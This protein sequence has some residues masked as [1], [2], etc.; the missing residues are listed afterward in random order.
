MH[1]L[2][3]RLR[4]KLRS[5]FRRR[6]LE[7][8]MAEEMRHHVELLE[9]ANRRAGL[10]P[11]EA[12]FAAR[13]QFGN[14]A[15]IQERAR[16][17]RGWRWL[18]QTGS[19]LRHGVRTALKNPGF[20]LVVIGTL[21]IGI[22]VNLAVFALLDAMFLRPLPG[23][24]H[25]SELV[26][27]G[28]AAGNARFGNT[29]YSVFRDYRAG[30]APVFSELA[31]FAEAEFGLA[32]ENRTDRVLGELVS[33]NYFTT[34]GVRMAAGRAFLPEEDEGA[35]RNPV[36]V[37]SFRLWQERWQGD[38]AVIGRTVSLNGHAC[39][40]VGVAERGFRALQLPNAHDIWVPLQMRETLF[41]AEPRALS[42]PGN[43]WL[44]RLVGKLA[45]GVTVEQAQEHLN[46][47]ARALQPAPAPG[48][49]LAWSHRLVEY[50]PFP[51]VNRTG[52]YAFFSILLAITLLVLG[53][54]TLNAANLFL[55]RA[56]A[57]R[58]ETA[59]RLALGASRG[60]LVRQM[61]AEGL[62]VATVAAGLGILGA[63]TAAAWLVGQIPGDFGDPLTV[64][65]VF[66]G[67]M[68]GAAAGLA[69]LT[70]LA[71]GLIPAWQGLQVNVLPALQTGEGAQTS[72]R[73]RLRSA[74]VVAQV[75]V[76]VVLVICAGLLARSLVRAEAAD[77]AG[78]TAGLLMA[79]VEP[80][81]N[82]YA[83]VQGR[84]LFVRW[85]EAVRRL[86]GVERAALAAIPPFADGS[87]STGP[88]YGGDLD[89]AGALSCNANVVADGYFDTVGLALLRGRDFSGREGPSE[90]PTVIVNRVLAGLL[91]PD[92]EPLG[93]LLRVAG[94]DRVPLLVIGVV[95]EDL[96]LRSSSHPDEARPM[97]Y[98]PVGQRPATAMSVLAATAGDP[99][100]LLPSIRAALGALDG[101]LPLFQVTTLAAARE[102]TLWRHRAV[103]SLAVFC[104]GAAL[105]LAMVG[106]SAAL[107]QDVQRRTREI[108]IRLAVGGSAR[109]VLSLVVGHGMRLATGGLAAGLVLAF[110]VARLLR[111][112]L[113]GVSPADP[114][115]FAVATV[116]IAAVSVAAC[117]L[118]ARR[119]ARV[120][121][122]VALRAE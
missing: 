83:D 25:A 62:I 115:T 87:M 106:L 93:Q 119:A 7:T 12:R 34:A 80:R 8:E 26:L 4:A 61:V 41:P 53:A 120:D 50:G 71:I 92:R 91:W 54:V 105:L 72:R 117:W 109:S 114:L 90:P 65:L 31:A 24:R 78:K 79:R 75:A 15:S 95:S 74:L 57:R 102:R 16:E 35:G 44:R 96:R 6:Q 1:P 67:R 84:Q 111:S 39:T 14:M 107:A 97:Y 103:G 52:P 36:V 27:L 59:V 9:A 58:R 47:L 29:S 73:S 94:D 49:R 56:L 89:A 63:N 5:L 10:P 2:L 116:V 66:G 110:G 40:I 21:A 112:V 121:P 45:P 28:R 13:R 70:A 30:V 48:E 104:S 108:G 51:T 42:D 18:E 60:R 81:L 69:A 20:S 122:I 3:S 46:A 37:I 113:I 22:G 76:S 17:Q 101:D 98:L 11:D 19:D 86:P 43:R 64:D 68:A 33:A 118:P 100:E 85:L 99:G 88:V 77:P 38:P 23:V 55:A 32:S 82:G